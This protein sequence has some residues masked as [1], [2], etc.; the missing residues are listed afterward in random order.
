MASPSEQ[1]K[2]RKV[3][4]HCMNTHIKLTGGAHFNTCG[5]LLMEIDLKEGLGIRCPRCK[6]FHKL[7]D[8]ILRLS[9][10][11][12]FLYSSKIISELS[13][14]NDALKNALFEKYFKPALSAKGELYS[15][16]EKDMA[17][18]MISWGICPPLPENISIK[19]VNY[20]RSFTIKIY[21]CWEKVTGDESWIGISQE[22]RAIRYAKAIEKFFKSMEIPVTLKF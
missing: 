15:L 13:D 6:S 22:D 21:S 12:A 4:L 9:A 17:Y 19:I 5:Q 18:I 14:F 20:G 7:E 3:G 10:R 11:R 16:Y 8:L 1:K 2:E